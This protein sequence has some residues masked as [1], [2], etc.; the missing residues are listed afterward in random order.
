MP[1]IIRKGIEIKNIVR[2]GCPLTKVYRHGHLIWIRGG[3]GDESQ[4]K[5]CFGN[6]YWVDT[7]PWIDTDGW[8]DN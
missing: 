4:N 8:K 7:L 1:N 5:S 6:G 3:G 2:K